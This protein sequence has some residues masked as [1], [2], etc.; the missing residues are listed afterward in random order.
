MAH[1]KYGFKC[2]CR[3]RCLPKLARKQPLK[4]LH[5]LSV[6]ILTNP[7]AVR[8]PTAASGSRVSCG[9]CKEAI[10]EPTN[11]SC[12]TLGSRSG[13]HDRGRS[14]QENLRGWSRFP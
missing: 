5:Y 14:V 4:I 10:M 12:P 11:T 13:D 3:D 7:C 1:I 9:C 6:K 8:S 2:C